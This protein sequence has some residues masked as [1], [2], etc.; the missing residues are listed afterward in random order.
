MIYIVRDSNDNFSVTRTP[1][2][3]HNVG[4]VSDLAYERNGS[5]DNRTMYGVLTL[6]C[7]QRL[8]QNELADIA[9]K[10]KLLN[11]INGI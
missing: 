10:T 9:L 11:F 2:M 3:A 8:L 7:E 6:H 5:S 1:P 4:V